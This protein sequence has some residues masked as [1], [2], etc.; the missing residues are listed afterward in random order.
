[1]ASPHPSDEERSPAGRTLGGTYVSVVVW[2]LTMVKTRNILRTVDWLEEPTWP[3]HHDRRY[4]SRKCAVATAS[5]RS[6]MGPSPWLVRGQAPRRR[7]G[8]MLWSCASSLYC[9]CIF[10]GDRCLQCYTLPVITF[11]LSLLNA[12]AGY[13]VFR[14]IGKWR[15]INFKGKAPTTPISWENKVLEAG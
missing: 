13:F 9:Q 2:K 14:W 7:R 8:E 15:L 1:M 5:H 3:L 12:I 4:D 11:C 10:F 6:K